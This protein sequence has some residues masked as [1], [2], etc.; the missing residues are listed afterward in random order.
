M[1]TVISLYIKTFVMKRL[2]ISICI[3]ACMQF[4]HHGVFAQLTSLPNGGNKR[5][6]V[7]EQVGLTD[8]TIRYSRPH[9]NHREGHIW[10]ELIPVGYVDQGFGTSKAAPWRAGANENTIIEFSTDVKIEGQPLAAGKY[11][12]FIAYDPGECTLIFSKN[13]T[14][15]G[16]FFYD[17]SE[18][19]LRVKVK[20]LMADKSAEWLKYEF[21]NETTGSAVV[22]LQWEKLIIPFSIETDV[23]HNQIELFR[24][25]LRSE[26][27]FIWQSW[28][29]A[30]LYCAKNKTN[31]PEALLWSDTATGVNVGGSQ[32]FQAWSTKAAVLDSMGR[33]T[34]AKEAMKKALPFGDVNELY[35]YARNLT[36]NKQGKEA[37]EI[38][39][40]DYDKHPNEFLT[41]AGMAR[42]YSAVGDYKKALTFAEKARTQ[43]TDQPNIAILDK[44]IKN[45]QDGKDVN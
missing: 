15:W 13:T 4:A 44:M 27:G 12:F 30:A 7:S 31:L 37:F 19:A 5:A 9:V 32:S 28:D 34:E 40:L 33:D 35:F 10:G 17:S 3:I 36:R 38:F 14:S 6:S 16:S 20:P 21:T 11:A 26:K 8:V 45:L 42:G 43:V 25:E 22:Q 1:L 24:K 41:N 18:D 23:V 39:K 29:Q 2:L